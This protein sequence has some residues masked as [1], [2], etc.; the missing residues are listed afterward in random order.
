MWAEFVD[1]ALVDAAMAGKALGDAFAAAD[2][3][4]TTAAS[5][6]VA[7]PQGVGPATKS[8]GR[9]AG[10][11]VRRAKDLREVPGTLQDAIARF[12]GTQAPHATMR[13]YQQ[14]CTAGQG[15]AMRTFCLVLVDA[16][17]AV[18]GI[19]LTDLE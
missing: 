9:V 10:V 11:E 12:V 14:L 7:A 15:R 1:V 6:A 5:W 17:D 16:A 8:G 4:P 2:A 18:A 3:V 13:N 19:A